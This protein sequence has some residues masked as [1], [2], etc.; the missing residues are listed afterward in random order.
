MAPVTAPAEVE[1]RLTQAVLAKAVRIYALTEAPLGTHGEFTEFGVARV[2]P[3]HQIVELCAGL[4]LVNWDVDLASLVTVED[5]VR[6]LGYDDMPP[7]KEE[8]VERAIQAAAS[9]VA[10][11]ILGGVAIA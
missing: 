1:A 5:V 10:S 6:A 9:W 4:L 8:D 7:G 2:M 3:D 11:Y